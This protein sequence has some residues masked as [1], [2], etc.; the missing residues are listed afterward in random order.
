MHG[1]ARGQGQLR[2]F[3]A[4]SPRARAWLCLKCYLELPE[5]ASSF[6]ERTERAS[7]GPF[8]LSVSRK[9]GML[10]GDPIP[11]AI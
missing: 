4:A 11:G 1:G 9:S 7:M 5:F 3:V 2:V 8:L 10:L 6:G